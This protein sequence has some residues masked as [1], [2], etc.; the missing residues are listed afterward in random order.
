MD[1]KSSYKTSQFIFHYFQKYYF[2]FQASVLHQ[3]YSSDC[4]Y[5]PLYK[6]KINRFLTG[7]LLWKKETFI[8]SKVGLFLCIDIEK[9]PTG[10]C[11]EHK[12]IIFIYTLQ[13]IPRHKNMNCKKGL[14]VG[15]SRVFFFN[16]LKRHILF[17]V[18]TVSLCHI[19]SNLTK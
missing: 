12:H 9:V 18:T 2:E 6:L 15:L 3:R 14:K 8:I 4:Y 11:S 1:T 13:C 17:P 19:W 16:I 5:T 7:V 10:V